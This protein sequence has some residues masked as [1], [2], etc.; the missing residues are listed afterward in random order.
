VTC[1]YFQDSTSCCL[2]SKSG[3]FRV[4]FQPH[5]DT[6]FQALDDLGYSTRVHRMVGSLIKTQFD[7]CPLQGQSGEPTT[8]CPQ[9]KE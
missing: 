7:V 4:W 6:D 9:Y 8:Y 5:P 3:A 1:K 2:I